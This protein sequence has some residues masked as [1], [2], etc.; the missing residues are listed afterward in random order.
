MPTLV[1]FEYTIVRVV[2]RVERDERLNVGVI[3]VCRPKQFLNARIELDKER[4]RAFAPYL[5]T[6]T[7]E[8]IEK[9]L[10]SIPRICRGE[11]D[12]GPIARLGLSER[13]HW[14]AAPSST[15]IQPGPVHTGLSID[16]S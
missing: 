15:L 8:L 5:E 9:Q 14:L 12:A 3:L 16:P 7:I 1:P 11:A 10:A 4:L 2:P 13:W 6:S